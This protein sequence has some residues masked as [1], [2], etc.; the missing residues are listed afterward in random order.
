MLKDAQCTIGEKSEIAEML[1]SMGSGGRYINY[2][3]G[4]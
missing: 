2:G 1:S 4:A 3:V